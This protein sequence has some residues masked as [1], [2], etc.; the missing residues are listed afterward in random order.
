M[1]LN[2]GI[3]FLLV[4]NVELVLHSAAVLELQPACGPLDGKTP[5]TVHG[6]SFLSSDDMKIDVLLQ[7]DEEKNHDQISVRTINNDECEFKTPSISNHRR[8]QRGITDVLRPDLP[9]SRI[10][11]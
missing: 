2:D 6:R 3:D 9:H 8:S 10:S 7:D 5:V 4:E 11:H 1:S